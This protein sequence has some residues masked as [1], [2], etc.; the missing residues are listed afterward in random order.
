MVGCENTEFSR[1]FA[2][3]V[4]CLHWMKYSAQIYTQFTARHSGDT[5]ITFY[6]PQTPLE[7]ETI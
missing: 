6:I 4:V 1:I 2:G 3:G 5:L 7:D